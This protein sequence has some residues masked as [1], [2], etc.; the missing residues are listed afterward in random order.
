MTDYLPP[1]GST[2]PRQTR[3]AV[4]AI[5]GGRLVTTG[6]VVADADALDWSGVAS[7]DAAIGESFVVYKDG[8]QRLVCGDDVVAGPVKCGAAGTVVVFDPD[9]DDAGAYVG[10]AQTDADADD[11]V[12]VSMSR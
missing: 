3:T 1:Y 9:T 4:G 2:P 12:L 8:V 10:E 6:D 5:V 7:H 11:P